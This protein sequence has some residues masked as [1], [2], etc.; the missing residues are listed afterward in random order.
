MLSDFN[1]QVIFYDPTDGLY[2]YEYTLT[3][4]EGNILESSGECIY[5][6]TDSIT[7]STNLSC[8]TTSWSYL[9][10]LN[11]NS[12]YY[13]TYTIKTIS[14]LTVSSMPYALIH[15]YAVGL[16]LPPL[17][18]LIA[19]AELDTSYVAVNL[20]A[21]E[22]DTYYAGTFEVLRTDSLSNYKV[23]EK[24]F[25]FTLDGQKLTRNLINDYTVQ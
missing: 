7:F 3:D 19:K 24:I 16:K 5:N 4:E 6:T 10:D 17:T 25:E 15:G 23:W 13:I 21:G 1:G 14:G 12:L 8:L 20:D 9:S 18:K 2:S 11:Y 22:N